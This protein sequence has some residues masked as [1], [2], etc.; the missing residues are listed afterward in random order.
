MIVIALDGPAGSG[1]STVAKSLS[2][3]LNIEYIDSGAIYRTLTLY[4]MKT[5]DNVCQGNE[6]EVAAY[7]QK[8]PKDVKI[9]YVDHVQKM[10]LKGEDV[11]NQIRTPEV[12]RQIKYIADN[13]D[14]RA[15]VNAIMRDVA[16]SYSAVIDGRDIGTKVFPDTPYKFYLDAKAEIRAKRRALELGIPIEGELFQKLL[17]DI[18]ERDKSDVER[19]IAPLCKAE[20]AILVDTSLLNADEVVAE[21]RA[22][23]DLPE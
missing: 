20:D 12:T 21:I 14:C 6:N 16:N 4:C 11:S 22:Q 19:T 2:Q 5:F 1:K 8:N 15:M 10:V 23:I 3:S 9:E 7:F 17:T 18:V 13:P